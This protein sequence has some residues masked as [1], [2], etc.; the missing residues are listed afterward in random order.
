MEESI[1][2]LVDR[3][4]SLLNPLQRTVQPAGIPAN[5]ADFTEQDTFMI[6][7]GTTNGK[8]ET[9]K[10]IVV[11]AFHITISVLCTY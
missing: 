11:D 8:Y 2:Q 9:I 5:R 7:V 4:K 6:V 3:M 10:V 1:E